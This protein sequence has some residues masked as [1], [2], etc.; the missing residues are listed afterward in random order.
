[1]GADSLWI[2]LLSPGLSR[3]HLLKAHKL[4]KLG[5]TKW[6]DLGTNRS[7]DPN[8]LLLVPF[9]CRFLLEERLLFAAHHGQRPPLLNEFPTIHQVCSW[10]TGK[11]IL[12][13]PTLTASNDALIARLNTRWDIG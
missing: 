6:Q 2:G 7:W 3:V 4:W 1:M 10:H 5:F 9:H 12:P 8:K 11:S 13:L